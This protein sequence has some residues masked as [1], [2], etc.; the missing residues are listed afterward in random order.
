MGDTLNTPY[1]NISNLSDKALI[2][3]RECILDTA[4]QFGPY[5]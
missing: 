1:V 3:A 5:E 2:K 4:T